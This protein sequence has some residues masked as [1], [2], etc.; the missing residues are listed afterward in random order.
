MAAAQEL[1]LWSQ[2]QKQKEENEPA[3]FDQ[4]DKDAILQM[5]RH[6]NMQHVTE[7]EPDKYTQVAEGALQKSRLVTTAVQCD[8]CVHLLFCLCVREAGTTRYTLKITKE[9]CIYLRVGV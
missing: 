2:T 8:V 3:W 1:P 5:L 7:F 6:N 9:T 4:N